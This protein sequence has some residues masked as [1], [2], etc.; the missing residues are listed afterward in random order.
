[1]VDGRCRS[2][3]PRGRLEQSNGN[4]TRTP[5]G[6]SFRITDPRKSERPSA[7]SD[8]PPIRSI[9]PEPSFAPNRPNRRLPA[10]P[11]IR[12]KPSD[13]A[14]PANRPKPSFPRFAIESAKTFGSSFTGQSP[15]NVVS[16][17]YDQIAQI[18]RTQLD[19]QIISR[20]RFPADRVD[21]LFLAGVA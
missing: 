9:P 12:P 14:L 15:K 20:R 4:G 13:P 8:L 2:G 10:L 3:H 5:T 17:R 16:P 21:R 19:P 6:K 1:M 11:P 7:I 18:R